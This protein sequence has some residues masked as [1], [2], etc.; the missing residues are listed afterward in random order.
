MTASGDHSWHETPGESQLPV[1]VGWGDL[2]R[3][4][5]RGLNVLAGDPGSN[6]GSQCQEGLGGPCQTI[7]CPSI[8]EAS[9]GRGDRRPW[10]VQADASLCPERQGWLACSC[11]RAAGT[12]LAAGSGP[13]PTF[14][15]SPRDC[16]LSLELLSITS[17]TTAQGKSWSS[18]REKRSTQR[19]WPGTGLRVCC[20]NPHPRG[21]PS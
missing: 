17:V 19:E 18:G 6:P 16:D 15:P 1:R 3:A 13:T 9:F 14:S 4:V 12:W 20:S 10:H 5:G 11:S 2:C 21:Q 7:A 8:K